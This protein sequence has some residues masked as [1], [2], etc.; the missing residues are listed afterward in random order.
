V[1]EAYNNVIRSHTPTSLETIANLY[2]NSEDY[3]KYSTRTK[4]NHQNYL[5][6]LKRVF[7]DSDM[8]KAEPKHI[9]DWR[10]ARGK[11]ARESANKELSFLRL[12]LDHSVTVGLLR[13]NP[14][15][16]V[17]K[18]PMS[19][20]EKQER[21]KARRKK[22]VTN[23]QYAAMY[24]IANPTI[25]AAMEILYCTGIRMGDLLRLQWKDVHDD[26]IDI[27]EGKTLND[28]HKEMSPRLASALREARKIEPLSPFVIHNRRGQAY[29]EDGFGTT[30]QK[31]RVKLPE[32]DRFGIH[33]IRHKSITDWKGDKQQFSQHATEAMAK[34]YDDSI[35][36]A[37]SH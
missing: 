21:R 16:K 14:A 9:N 22:Y 19:Q 37:P 20:E 33:Q 10:D 15:R 2:F 18:L 36:K 30:W 28:Y 26:Y 1:W 4:K 23:R 24:K 35:P 25:R 32:H 29:T 5:K 8:A 3:K 34:H 12:V 13:D 7:G 6:S 31:I 11:Q 27:E 17:K